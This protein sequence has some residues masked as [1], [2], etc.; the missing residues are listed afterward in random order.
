MAKMESYLAVVST[1]P[2]PGTGSSPKTL[3][4]PS[5]NALNAP[6]RL[7]RVPPSVVS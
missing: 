7:F 3:S 6:G 5:T 1:L 2:T 4:L